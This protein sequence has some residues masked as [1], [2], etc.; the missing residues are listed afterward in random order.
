MCCEKSAADGIAI[1]EDH[2]YID[3]GVSGSTIQRDDFQ[4]MLANIHVGN[5]PDVL[6][7]KDDKR[8]FRNERE[9]GERVEWNWEHDI[10]IRYCL[11]TFGDPRASDE[12]W[13]TQRM[14]HLFAELERRRKAKKT[15]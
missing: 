5:F 14:Y 15:F 7:A 1:D 11:V 2:I 12:Q 9:A 3:R 6:Y 8:L 4:H 13:F 10:E